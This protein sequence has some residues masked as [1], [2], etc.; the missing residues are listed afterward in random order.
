MSLLNATASAIVPAYNEAGTIE[1]VIWDLLAISFLNEIII[2]NDGS[3]DGTA[4]ILDKHSDQ[5]MVMTNPTN[6]GKGYS[7]ARGLEV[8]SG[9]LIL[10]LDSDIINYTEKDL[11]SLMEPVLKN[12][13]D[14]TIKYARDKVFH[15]LSGIR[16]YRRI[17]LLPLVPEMKRSSRFGLEIFLNRRLKKFKVKY[18]KLFDYHHLQKF[19]KH[20][21]PKVLWEY[22][23]ELISI[24]REI[25]R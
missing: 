8:A 3:F 22:L 17:D 18:I 2:V 12:E 7:V 23:K 1:G 16:C 15:L 6:K 19:E 13:C 14:F 20:R 21:L 9:D 24:L 11:R 25:I 4:A 10:L 5:V